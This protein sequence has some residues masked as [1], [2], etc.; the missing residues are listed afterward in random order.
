MEDA[1]RSWARG[2]AAAAVRGSVAG[3][4]VCREV[5]C[6][7]RLS[8]LSSPTRIIN[9][10]D[11]GGLDVDTE[12]FYLCRVT[13]LHV[14]SWRRLLYSK[15]LE[16]PLARLYPHYPSSIGSTASPPSR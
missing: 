2:L 6:W 10:L 7:Y 8:Q 13:Y 16:T 12:A 9:G 15:S 3:R 4:I 14:L 1:E 5:I 11:A